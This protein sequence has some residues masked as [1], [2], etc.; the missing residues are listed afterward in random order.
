MVAQVE[1][2][3]KKEIVGK[4]FKN[5]NKVWTSVRNSEQILVVCDKGTI[6]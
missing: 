6:M 1:P 2:W 4:N 3:N 5:R